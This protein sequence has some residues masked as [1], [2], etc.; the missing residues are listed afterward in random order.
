MDDKTKYVKG[1]TPVALSALKPGT[2][3]VIAAHREGG[4]MIA[5]EVRI[6]DDASASGR[7]PKPER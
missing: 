6:S 4:K 7:E 2:R 3:V 1:S 5:T